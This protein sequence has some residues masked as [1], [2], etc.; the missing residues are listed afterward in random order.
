MDQPEQIRY[1]VLE[2]GWTIPGLELDGV[3]ADAGGA[4]ELMLVPRVSPPWAGSPGQPPAS[5]I[6]LDAACHLFLSNTEANRIVRL[7]LDCSERLEFPGAAS[8][9]GLGNLQAPAG[10]CLGPHQTLFVADPGG[11]RLVLLTAD[12]R[13]RGFWRSGLRRPVAVVADGERAVIVL[14]AARTAVL[15]FDAWGYPDDDFNKR[16]AAELG[17]AEPQAIAVD[18]E[19]V[20]YVAA[21]STDGIQRFDRLGDPVGGL[22]APNL[23]AQALAVGKE[24]LFAADLVS[25]TIACLRL[26]DGTP[27]GTV[28]GFRGA[29]SALAA[30]NDGG[31]FIKPDAGDRYL[32]AVRGGARVNGGQ[33]VAGPIDA[34]GDSSWGR[35]A[36]DAATPAETSISLETFVTDDLSN[37]PVFMRSDSLDVLL[38]GGRYLYLRVQL[39]TNDSTVSP[40]IAR[41]QGETTGDSYLD[42]LPEV[43]ARGVTANDFLPRLLAIAHSELGDLEATID[44]LPSLF[45]AG[46]ARAADLAFLGSWQAFDLPPRIDPAS[47]PADARALLH[48]IPDLYRRRGTPSGIQDFVEIYSGVRPS[49]FE[50]FRSA[51]VWILDET[52]VLGFDTVLPA[53]APDGMIVGESVVGGTGLEPPGGWAT[54]A[55]DDTAFRFTVSVAGALSDDQRGWIKRM[56]DREKPA[57]TGYHLCFVEPRLRVGVQARVGIDAM[58]GSPPVALQLDERAT[59]GVDARLGDD[60]TL[61]GTGGLSAR[62]GIDTTLA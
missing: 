57:H 8:G 12:L 4:F 10:L 6:C 14:D 43:Y 15:R 20:L 18:P 30:S 62:V 16:L 51:G 50:A 17:S 21:K 60:Q 59:L 1:F 35:V 32:V 19:G 7:G 40:Q 29:V 22:I 38:V 44:S 23:R 33:I 53:T 36:V 26:P 49:I 34:G 5:G 39:R 37:P 24:L 31:L 25:G 9:G 47:N 56:L 54:T 42:Y 3:M 46:M 58:V 45:D 55:F 13:L 41:I 28:A 2:P 48:R 27:A 61:T 52:S 11:G